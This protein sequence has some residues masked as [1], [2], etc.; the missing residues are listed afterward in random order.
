MLV[1]GF[2]RSGRR[3]RGS[4]SILTRAHRANAGSVAEMSAV[5]PSGFQK[6]LLS[7][8]SGRTSLLQEPMLDDTITS[9]EQRI[10][11]EFMECP[12]LRL[13][14]AQAARFWGLD[15]PTIERVLDQLV[16]RARLGGQPESWASEREKSSTREP[17]LD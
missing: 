4:Q 6:S 14:T 13:T 2:V 9:W 7:R 15:P 8:C 5:A 12:E 17:T 10:A 3:Y 1:T 11:N 16:Q